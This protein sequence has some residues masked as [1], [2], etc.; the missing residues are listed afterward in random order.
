MWAHICGGYNVGVE[1]L[2]GEFGR[3]YVIG[4]LVCGK[5]CRIGDE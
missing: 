4:G 3:V 1:M 5:S 2:G